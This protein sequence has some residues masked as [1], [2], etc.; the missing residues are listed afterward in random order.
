MPPRNRVSFGRRLRGRSAPA[1]RAVTVRRSP[2]PGSRTRLGLRGSAKT[3]FNRRVKPGMNPRAMLN[4]A[5]GVGG[6]TQ[7]NHKFRPDRRAFTMEKVG[8]RNSY[9]T[10]AAYRIDV[11]SGFQQAEIKQTADAPTLGLIM[12]TLNNG[13]HIGQ[14][15]LA[16]VNAVFSIANN[17]SSSAHIDVYDIVYKRSTP[18]VYT[19]FHGTVFNQNEAFTLWRG[20][21]Q[22]QDTAGLATAYEQLMCK[23]TASRMFNDYVK[24]L[25]CK[26]ILLGSGSTH[27]HRVNLRYNKVISS[28]VIGTNSNSTV[29]NGIYCLQGLTHSCMIVAYGSPASTGSSMGDGVLVSTAPVAIDVVYQAQYNYTW[30]S[31]ATNTWNS[32]DNLSS[33]APGLGQQVVPAFAVAA[34]VISSP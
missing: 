13:T 5:P 18:T 30:V 21:L 9:S 15:A 25:R 22:D 7:L 26:R 12:S 28:D 23:P 29:N 31:D 6:Q 14:Y 20:G 27:E 8:A 33:F 24:V 17:S 19:N 16:N 32:Q 2:Y 34:A 1:T 10:N 11:A 3:L 4:I